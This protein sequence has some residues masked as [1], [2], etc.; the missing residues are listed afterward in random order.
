MLLRSQM[1]ITAK[2]N[3]RWICLHGL[4]VS[5]FVGFKQYVLLSFFFLALGLT[6]WLLPHFTHSVSVSWLRTVC[7]AGLDSVALSWA[8]PHV[9]GRWSP[10]LIRSCSWQEWSSLVLLYTA[11]AGLPGHAAHDRASTRSVQASQPAIPC[12]HANPGAGSWAGGGNQAQHTSWTGSI[13]RHK[14]PW[15][16]AEPCAQL[17]A[18]AQMWQ[19]LKTWRVLTAPE[20]LSQL[21]WSKK[22][23]WVTTKSSRSGCGFKK[24]WKT[25][26]IKVLSRSSTKRGFYSFTFFSFSFYSQVANQK[27]FPNVYHYSARGL[28]LEISF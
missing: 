26:Q 15:G 24:E 28:Q 8:W 16:S 1:G 22:N 10:S 23:I 5:L 25:L 6:C 7:R 14:T 11:G 27:L 3:S 2:F 18:L 20:P 9:L 19:S 17:L 4:F 21:K 13:C 12:L